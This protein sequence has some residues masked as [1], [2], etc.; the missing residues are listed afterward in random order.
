MDPI[1]T[2]D[3]KIGVIRQKLLA[4]VAKIDAALTIHDFRVVFGPTHTNLVFDIALP[5]D[6]LKQKADIKSFVEQKMREQTG[7]V[8]YAVITFDPAAFNQD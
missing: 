8:Y 3:E 1:D 7:E 2:S 6:L 5:D 4:E